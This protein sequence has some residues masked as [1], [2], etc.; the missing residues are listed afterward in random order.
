MRFF[1]YY[2]MHFAALIDFVVTEVH[3][4]FKTLRGI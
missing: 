4:S 3:C 1:F 2:R